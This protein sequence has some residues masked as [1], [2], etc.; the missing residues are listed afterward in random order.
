M[1]V[2]FCP[3]VSH[4]RVL[5]HEVLGRGA[6]AI[7]AAALDARR[8]SFIAVPRPMPAAPRRYFI[9]VYRPLSAVPLV[10]RRRYLIVKPI[11]LRIN[12]RRL[13]HGRSLSGPIFTATRL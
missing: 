2:S 9:V 11:G 7:F 5:V 10:E 12:R 3:V 1:Y 8:S 4:A 13:P 6:Q